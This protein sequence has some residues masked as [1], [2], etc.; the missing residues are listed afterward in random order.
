[1]VKAYDSVRQQLQRSADYNK[2]YYDIGVRPSRFEAGQ[3][4]WYFN[5]RKFQRKQMKWTQQ[6]E[7]PYLILEVPTPLTVKIQQSSRTKPKIVHIDKLKKYEGEK[8]KMWSTAE[9]AVAAQQDGDREGATVGEAA[10]EHET[11][12][13]DRVAE[14]EVLQDARPDQPTS[15]P[16]DNSYFLPTAEPGSVEPNWDNGESDSNGT[17][18]EPSVDFE[19]SEEEEV[20]YTE[21]QI[22]P[23][24]DASEYV[25]TETPDTNE[26]T[27]DRRRPT[28]TTRRPTRFQGFETNFRPEERRRKCFQLGKGDK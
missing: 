22:A 13:N 21:T 23:T 11:W 19:E 8:P 28:R 25:S 24:Q 4:V 1:M 27:D 26:W 14:E 17:G 10:V 5:P 6:Y 18:Q 16:E 12:E 15:T 3:W 9:V 7:G 2:R 20:L